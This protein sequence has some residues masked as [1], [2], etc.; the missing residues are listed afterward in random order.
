LHLGA[1]IEVGHDRQER[2]HL[3]EAGV[4]ASTAL[5]PEMDDEQ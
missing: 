2:R 3:M 5:A 1:R 4:P